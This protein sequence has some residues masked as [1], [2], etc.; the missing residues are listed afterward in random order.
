MRAEPS[1]SKEFEGAGLGLA[2]VKWVVENHHGRVAVEK[3]GRTRK[4]LQHLAADRHGARP[5]RRNCLI[6]LNLP[7]SLIR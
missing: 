6:Y 3:S 2:L 7:M 5:N 4:L 1:R